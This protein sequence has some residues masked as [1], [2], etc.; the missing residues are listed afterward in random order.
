[1]DAEEAA[2][3]FWNVYMENFMSRHTKGPWKISDTGHV[4]GIVD[5]NVEVL[6]ADTY[7]LEGYGK[8]DPKGEKEANTNLIA[9]APE[10]LEACKQ[11][12]QSIDYWGQRALHIPLEESKKLLID[13]G[14]T[15]IMK[16]ALDAIAK[17]EGHKNE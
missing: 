11:L 10:L 14:S 1:M 12:V 4:V 8:V 9:A 6:I 2:E 17:A 3:L 15:Q 13:L 5:V 16:D 7:A